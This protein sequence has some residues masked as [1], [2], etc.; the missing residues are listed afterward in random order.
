MTTRA[1]KLRQFLWALLLLLGGI[2]PFLVFLR[3]DFAAFQ[4][5]NAHAAAADQ[6]LPWTWERA[7][8]ALIAF[9]CVPIG[10]FQLSYRSFADSGPMSRGTSWQRLILLWACILL[11]AL[12]VY[13]GSPRGYF[14]W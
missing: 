2:I 8:A 3:R 9:V 4:T 14:K 7:I 11:W 6:P 12:M 13:L 5:V 10:I 1:F